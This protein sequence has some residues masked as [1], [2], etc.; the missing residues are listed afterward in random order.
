LTASAPARSK[1]DA[2]IEEATT[3]S[4][5][6]LKAFS[7]GEAERAKGLELTA[8]P[9]YKHAI[10]PDLNFAVAYARWGQA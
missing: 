8:I 10:E 2:P 4:L 9:F 3:S 6:A 5:E 1:F 7:L